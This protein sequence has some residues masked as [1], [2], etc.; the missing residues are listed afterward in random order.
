MLSPVTIPNDQIPLRGYDRH[1]PGVLDL[2]RAEE[3]VADLFDR[4][5][6]VPDQRQTVDTP[7]EEAP[8]EP[9]MPAA[10]NLPNRYSKSTKTATKAA[11]PRTPAGTPTQ[12]SADRRRSRSVVAARHTG[13]CG[14]GCT[15]VAVRSRHFPADSTPARRR[16]PCGRSGP[17]SGYPR[18]CRPPPKPECRAARR[19]PLE[20]VAIDRATHPEENH[21]GQKR[22]HH[23]RQPAKD[24]ATERVVDRPGRLGEFSTM[25]CICYEAAAGCG[26]FRTAAG[27]PLPV[28]DNTMLFLG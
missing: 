8:E 12:R 1:H 25:V 4:R 20:H 23:H 5:V 2:P 11:P 6:D 21:D 10:M 15:P 17:D 22:R 14:P 26:C 16:W 24:R 3:E 18:V 13:P 28:F 19:S 9:P 27:T 7:L